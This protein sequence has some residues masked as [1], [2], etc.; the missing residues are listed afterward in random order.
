MDERVAGLA[1]VCIYCRDGHSRRNFLW[2]ATRAANGSSEKR[3]DPVAP[4]RRLCPGG[5]ELCVVDYGWI[6]GA[7]NAPNHIYRSGI[8]LRTGTFDRS[9][10]ERPRVHTIHRA[11]LSRS[12]TEPPA[13]NTWRY[14]RLH[15]FESP[16]RQYRGDA[17]WGRCRRPPNADLPQLGW[18]GVL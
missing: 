17:Y 3:P 5:G 18:S 9:G 4:T 2:H 14:F 6:A 16:A 15:G 13:E 7:R 1:S 11:S 12:V 10:I 8:W